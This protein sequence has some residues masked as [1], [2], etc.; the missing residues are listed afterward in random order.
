[1]KKG[2]F[3]ILFLTS[4]LSVAAPEEFLANSPVDQFTRLTQMFA[5]AKLPRIADIEGWHAGRCYAKGNPTQ[6]F[7]TILITET[8]ELNG[9]QGPLF[10]SDH[11]KRF[12]LISNSRE[13]LDVYDEW[14]AKTEAE[15]KWVIDRNFWGLSEIKKDSGNL[16]SE[17]SSAN[18]RYL[19]RK[20]DKYLVA[21]IQQLVDSATDT[22]GDITSACYFFKKLDND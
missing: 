9:K 2:L 14:N 5:Q 18:V 15:L 20:S 4:S 12:L 22:A 11:V 17:L 21:E 13:G 10:P 3:S 7:A 16:V 1:M 6:A 19:V 8:K